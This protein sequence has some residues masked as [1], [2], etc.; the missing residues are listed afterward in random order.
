MS[1]LTSGDVVR[2]NLPP[3]RWSLVSHARDGT[4][5]EK[6]A[7]LSELCEAY[8]MPL[9]FFV[10]RKG[11]SATDAE[12]LTQG[13]F[14]QLIRQSLFTRADANRGRLRTFLLTALERYLEDERG[15]AGAA[16]RGGGS[17]ILS[18]D[19]AGAEDQFGKDLATGFSPAL[20]FEREWALSVMKRA[21]VKTRAVYES[22]GRLDQFTALEGYILRGEEDRPHAEV[23]A[24]LGISAGAVKVAV[25]RLRRCYQET[26]F[27]TVLDTVHSHREAEDELRAMAALFAS[28]NSGPA[29]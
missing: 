25:C 2:G 10:R 28:L 26:L 21:L 6:H 12:D 20:L 9:Y 1:F 23:A 22:T 3:T 24:L 19:V 7:A 13:F 18:M 14:A 4:A 15:R 11:N 5:D 27:Q 16:K 29:A 17:Q 8:W